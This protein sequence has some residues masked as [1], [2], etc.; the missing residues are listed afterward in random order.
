MA[1][2]TT[3][4]YAL[5]SLPNVYSWFETAV[6]AIEGR[7]KVIRDHVR[8]QPGERVLDI[9]C[10]PG[11]VVRFLPDGVHYVGFDENPAY[12]RSAQKAFAG[13][14]EFYCERVGAATLERLPEFDVVMA[15]GILHHLGDEEAL[16]LF[17]LAQAAVRPGGR[18]FTLDGCFVPEQSWMARWLLTKD[19]GKNVR[20]PEEYMRLARAVF[21][22][23]K[24]T[25]RFDLCRIPNTGL[26]LECRGSASSNTAPGS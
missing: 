14:A 2:A 22:E 24:P 7:G 4:L 16:H 23:V 12:I 1:Q 6:G 20:T 5:L 8:P 18:V 13:R 15:L 19:R 9:G 21:P 26:I 17:R 10:G 25:V 11:D 3:G